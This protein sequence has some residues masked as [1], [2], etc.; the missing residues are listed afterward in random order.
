[1][2]QLCAYCGKVWEGNYTIHRDGVGKGPKV[3]ICNACTIGE[4]PSLDDIWA[5]LSVDRK[6]GPRLIETV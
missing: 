3:P 1:M 2:S 5:K 6:S 4:E